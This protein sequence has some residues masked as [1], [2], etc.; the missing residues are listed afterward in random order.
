[1]LVSNS[2][3][4][5]LRIRSSCINVSEKASKIFFAVIDTLLPFILLDRFNSIWAKGEATFAE[6][7]SIKTRNYQTKF[8][9]VRKRTVGIGKGIYLLVIAPVVAPIMALIMEWKI[10]IPSV[11]PSSG[12]EDLSG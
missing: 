3:S 2:R 12:S 9:S 6:K 8:W 5:G 10:F 7:A 1:M 11:P 4:W